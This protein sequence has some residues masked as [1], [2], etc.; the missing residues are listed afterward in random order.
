MRSDGLR[1]CLSVCLSVCPYL[2]IMNRST[3]S[4]SGIG[5][6][7]FSLKLLRSRG[8]RRETRA[9]ANCNPRCACAS[10]VER[11][12]LWAASLQLPQLWYDRV[13]MHAK[14]TRDMTQPKSSA[15]FVE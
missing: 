3:Y 14:N 4:A 2:D 13:I 5:R 15:E 6:N 9:K 11:S 1:V 10:R 7:I 8:L 12:C